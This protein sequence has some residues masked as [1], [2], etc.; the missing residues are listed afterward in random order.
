MPIGK[1]FLD[2][3][4]LRPVLLGSAAYKQYFESQFRNDRR[5]VSKYVLM[6][7]KRSYISKIL[8]F[9][10]VLDMPYMEMVGDAITFWSNAYKTSDLKAII[11]FI[12]EIINSFKLIAENPKEKEKAL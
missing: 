6:E 10:F 12:A 4:V 8:N 7:F 2:T 3:S 9:Y 1:R 5:Y 11:Q